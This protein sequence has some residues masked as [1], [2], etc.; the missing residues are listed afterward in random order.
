MICAHHLLDENRRCNCLADRNAWILAWVLTGTVSI[1]YT[2]RTLSVR[3]AAT[4]WKDVD[5]ASA[6]RIAT[7]VP[8]KEKG[9]AG[10]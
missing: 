5:V 1:P 2:Y 4:L 8:E 3:A 10:P 7:Y 6:Q 9:K